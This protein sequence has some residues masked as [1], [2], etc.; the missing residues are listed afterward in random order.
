M[1]N[2]L[3]EVIVDVPLQGKHFQPYPSTPIIFLV[4][5]KTE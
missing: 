3:A 4:A 2:M 1:S 5:F